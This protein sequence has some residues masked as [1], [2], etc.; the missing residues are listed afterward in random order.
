MAR[1]SAIRNIHAPEWGGFPLGRSNTGS[2]RTAAERR[3]APGWSGPGEIAA[4]ALL[5]VVWAM[6]WAF[7][8]AGVVEPAAGMRAAADR[9]RAEIAAASPFARPGAGPRSVDTT[10]GGP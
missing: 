8:I 6:L 3:R 9:P 5:V 7:F 4:G 1:T 2:P 10:G